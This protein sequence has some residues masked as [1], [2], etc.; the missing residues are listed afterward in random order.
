VVLLSWIEIHRTQNL[1]IELYKIAS[2]RIQNAVSDS[3]NNFVEVIN[4]RLLQN[5]QDALSCIDE[6]KT[7]ITINVNP[8]KVLTA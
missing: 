6:L 5:V 7:N 1:D 4:L 8:D 2:A 3:T